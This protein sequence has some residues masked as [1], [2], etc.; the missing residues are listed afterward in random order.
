MKNA[1]ARPILGSPNDEDQPDDWAIGRSA[2]D[3]P[4]GKEKRPQVCRFEDS[5]RGGSK[6]K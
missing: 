3:V 2:R 4:G 6:R 5:W 1:Q